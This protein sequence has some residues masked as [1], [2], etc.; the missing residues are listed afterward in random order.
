MILLRNTKNY[1]R[2]MWA[3]DQK[4]NLGVVYSAQ[5]SW[6]KHIEKVFAVRLD[7]LYQRF[8]DDSNQFSKYSAL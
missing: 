8:E 3:E 2:R 7:L 4:L 5:L 6:S 1:L